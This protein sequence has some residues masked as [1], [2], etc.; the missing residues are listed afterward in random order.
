MARHMK[1]LDEYGINFPRY[2]PEE[3]TFILTVHPLY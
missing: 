1:S 2:A 3:K